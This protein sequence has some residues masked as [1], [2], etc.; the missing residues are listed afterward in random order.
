[1][2][3]LI[4][5][6]GRIGKTIFHHLK[7]QRIRAF[8][9]EKKVK[10]AD[11]IVNC[12][13]GKVATKGF[14]LAFLKNKDLIDIS[15]VD[16]DF[17]FKRRKQIEKKKI[18]VIPNCGFCP[19]LLNFILAFEL[20]KKGTEKVEIVA[21]SFSPKKFFFPFLWC[22]EDLILEHKI[23]S[24]QFLYKKRKKFPPF[25]GYRLEKFLKFE[26]ESYFAPSGLEYLPKKLKIKNFTFRVLRPKG[27]FHFFKFLESYGLF[28]GKEK[29]ILKKFL[30]RKKEDNFTMAKIEIFFQKR[31]ISI[32]LKSFSRKNEKFNSMQKITSI[33][34]LAIIKEIS[35]GEFKEKGLI[36][37]EDL[38]KKEKISKKIMNFIKNQNFLSFAKKVE[39]F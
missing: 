14:K 27:F 31:K 37:P 5:G 12:L 26:T 32:F 23:P 2:N 3:V 18:L 36:F 33:L 28:D 6:K 39:I 4:L 10:E 7:K 15:D 22:F 25:S 24:F 35:S 19:G 13:P 9:E 38:A 29:E 21:G 1:M 34:P 20:N 30:E 11:L 17:Y 16:F 8:F